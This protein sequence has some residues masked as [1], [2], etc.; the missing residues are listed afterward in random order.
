MRFESEGA[1]G[2]LLSHLGPHGSPWKLY[3][4]HCPPGASKYIQK[5]PINRLNGG[6]VL[7]SICL[8]DFDHGAVNK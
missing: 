5:L 1:V 7:P 6:V 4:A 3:G 2:A 8:G